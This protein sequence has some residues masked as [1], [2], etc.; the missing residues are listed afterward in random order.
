[1]MG[2]SFPW[3]PGKKGAPMHALRFV[4]PIVLAIC[5]LGPALA[6][7][8]VVLTF[9][10]HE[11]RIAFGAAEVAK[12]LKARAANVVRSEPKDGAHRDSPQI[13]LTTKDAAQDTRLKPEGF[14]IHVDNRA[15][16][17]RIT[18][19]GADTAGAMYGGLELAEMIRIGGLGGVR[20]V[21][22]SPYMAMRGTKFN[23]PLDVRTP[24]YTDVCD[25]AQHNIPEMWSFEFWKEYFDTLARYRYNFVSF[26]SLH[27]FPSLVKVPDYPDV[28]LADVRR[29][30]V[31]WEENYS[32]NGVGFDAP[33]ILQNV[34]MI[35]RMT[36]EEKIAFWRQVMRYA[37][38]RNIKIYFVTW[39]VFVNGTGGKY[40][41][42]DAID[43]PTTRDYFRKSVAQMFLT[44]PDLAGIGLT[45]GENMHGASTRQ[46]EDWAFDTY[47]R[48]VLDAAKKL[49]GRKITLI[50]RQHQ[51]GATD[52]AKRFAPLIE[53][54]DVDFLF[55]FKYAKA[56]VYSS[57]TQPYHRKFVEEI[58]DLRTI[59]TLR[60]D[61]IYYFRWGAPDFVRQFLG[62][63]PKE[64]SRGFYYGSDQYVW[65]REFLS[66]RPKSPREIEVAKHWYQWML[67]GRLGYEPGLSNE[68]IV[69][70]LEARFPEVEAKK[71]FEAWQEASMIYPVTTG[72]HWG[73]LD[74]QWYIEGCQSRP[75]P[76]QTE[77]GFHDVNR[78]I[79]LA[80][81]P[82]R[83]FVSIPE[84]VKA[85]KAGRKPEGVTPP[86]VARRLHA[87]VDKALALLKTLEAGE[88]DDLGRTLADIRAMAHLGK[89]YAHKIGGATE[90]AL[91]RATHKA[92][93]REA[94]V[95]ELE[96]AAGCWKQYME[97]AARQYINPLW[98]NRV[99]YVDWRETY[100]EVLEDIEIARSAA[101]EKR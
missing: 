4:F 85:V 31:K 32:L 89:Y 43:N 79:T 34:E 41:I 69:G 16:H 23:I 29:S 48:G 65:G 49:P 98:T 96:R 82:S 59:W 54:P 45:T 30:T 80:P 91:F 27:P 17:P 6:A 71:L 7:E 46:K 56:H 67:W 74:F 83:D 21:K 26:W 64:V 51:T 15:Q 86:E 93:H 19:R 75:G 94:A 47:G 24:S 18:V 20:D 55:S 12:A 68:R 88:D 1:M 42:T 70:I 63:I 9:D 50:H 37:R 33:E 36:I 73:S 77:S 5:L 14:S 60:N 87:H 40:G 8:K 76:A 13:A 95:R 78:F 61:D 84:Y 100:G 3:S 52:V 25:A 28:A 72:F 66:L 92:P 44:Y 90:L 10:S 22:R 58:G 39:N 57:T 81:H 11:P 38:D 99:G 53:H 35:K 62:N 2:G 97:T 101:T